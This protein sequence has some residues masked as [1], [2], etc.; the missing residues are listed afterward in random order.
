M[1]TEHI[2]DLRSLR[3]YLVGDRRNMVKAFLAD[4][5]GVGEM[6][7]EFIGLQQIIDMVERAIAHE[8]SLDPFHSHGQ[9]GP[10]GD[11]RPS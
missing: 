2:A 10:G 11:M 9:H 1:E 7:G 8:H 4:P 5:H 6:G 3:D